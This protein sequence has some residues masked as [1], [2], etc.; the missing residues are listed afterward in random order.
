MQA[1]QHGF[2]VKHDIRVILNCHLLLSYA[3]VFIVN[4]IVVFIVVLRNR[5]V[6]EKRHLSQFQSK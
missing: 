3:F 5:T 6:H 2:T 1:T 4:T